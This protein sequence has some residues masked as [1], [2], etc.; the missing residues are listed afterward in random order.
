MQNGTDI[1]P[2]FSLSAR[3]AILSA[4][5]IISLVLII[6]GLKKLL[7]ILAI[8]TQ[9]QTLNKPKDH[10]LLDKALQQLGVIYGQYTSRAITPQLAAGQ[11]S[12]LVR[13]TF[14]EL[15]NHRTHYEARYE[16]AARRL[17]KME[18]FL[19]AGYPVEFA[20]NAEFSS[21]GQQ[22][23]FTLAREVLESCR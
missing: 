5:I 22:L 17:Q 1:Y 14:D 3:Y 16:I 7:T 12:E 19:L 18:A 13:K 15:M 9:R 6:L 10:T 20:K 2:P 11:T 4:L 23:F 21:E 8:R